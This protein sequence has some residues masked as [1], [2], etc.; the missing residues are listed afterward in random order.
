MNSD[1]L[2]GE[3]CTTGEGDKDEGLYIVIHEL[4]GRTT[5]NSNLAVP[6]AAPWRTYACQ[7]E[8]TLLRAG[9]RGKRGRQMPTSV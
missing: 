2:S 1:E 7:V 4:Q 6:L 9:E 3:E 5:E 8:R